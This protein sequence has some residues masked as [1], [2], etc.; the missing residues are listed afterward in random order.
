[1][2]TVGGDPVSVN[3]SNQ[4]VIGLGADV[5]CTINNNDTKAEP[6]GTTVQ[7]WVLHDTLTITGIRPGSPDPAASVTFRLYD[8]AGCAAEDLVD[9]E[10][11]STISAGGVASTTTG[12]PVTA[13]GFYYWTAQY[14]GDQYNEG[15]TTACG[16]EI[17]QIQ[18]KDAQGGGRDNLILPN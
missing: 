18:A 11:D 1:M 8:A 4:V 5:T 16:A 3:S 14:T 9:S 17:T 15:F 13:T 10:T 7:T 12:I 2:K 6:S